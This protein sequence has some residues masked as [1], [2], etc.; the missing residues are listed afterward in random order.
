MFSTIYKYWS[1]RIHN[2]FVAGQRPRDK[3]KNLTLSLSLS[4]R[5][6]K[7]KKKGRDRD[8]AVF[9][10]LALPLQWLVTW[11]LVSGTRSI[12]PSPPDFPPTTFF[13]LFFFF[14]SSFFFFLAFF[15]FGC[16]LLVIVAYITLLDILKVAY[17]TLSDILLPY[18]L[19]VCLYMYNWVVYEMYACVKVFMR[20][21]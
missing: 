8:G 15:F 9:E 10:W 21:I 1:S 3:I 16:L 2:T 12:P 4:D 14:F 18:L 5:T 11:D 20:H 13:L 6:K 17:M 7:E 19:D